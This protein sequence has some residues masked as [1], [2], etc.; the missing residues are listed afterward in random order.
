MEAKL[1][2]TLTQPLVTVGIPA[3]NR[4]KSLKY[5]LESITNQTYKNI[6][7]IVSD[8]CSPDDGVAAVVKEIQ[9]N[10][11][12]VKFFRQEKNLD[13]VKNHRFLLN[14]A[15]GKYLIWLSDDDLC[16]PKLVAT[17]VKS[18]EE[19]ENAI[20]CGCNVRII[21]EDGKLIRVE[22]LSAFHDYDE[23]RKVRRQFFS[24]PGANLYLLYFGLFRTSLMRKYDIGPFT[25]C[26]GYNSY[27]EVPF[28]AKVASVGE[29]ITTD[30]TLL[31]YRNHSDSRY[32][33]EMTRMTLVDR[34][35]VGL[36]VRQKLVWIALSAKISIWERIHFLYEIARSF[37]IDSLVKT[38]P[39]LAI[40]RIRRWFGYTSNTNNSN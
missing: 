4:P 24:F 37:F 31:S 23:W 18:M 20:V 9:F 8:D 40:K 17:L 21:D 13:A 29:I 6:E 27:M 39:F 12:R 26:H 15:T 38:L 5:L 33:K 32:Y 2:N 7:I 14:E 16:E 28:L 34:F 19:N 30:E 10:D 36:C 22:K 11:P 35:F 25:G 1:V 3:Y